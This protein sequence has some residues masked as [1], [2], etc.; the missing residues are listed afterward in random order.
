MVVR[1]RQQYRPRARCFR[2]GIS[3]LLRQ[4]RFHTR[5][6]RIHF[7]WRQFLSQTI[8][9]A[10]MGCCASRIA[11][12]RRTRP[13]QKQMSVRFSGSAAIGGTSFFGT[14]QT[15]TAT[16][17]YQTVIE[18]N[19]NTSAQIWNGVKRLWF[20][21]GHGRDDHEFAQHQRSRSTPTWWKF[22]RRRRGQRLNPLA[23]EGGFE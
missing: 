19:N 12:N 6:T 18:N 11:G 3:S 5:E 23:A 2:H 10:R 22:S 8:R 17:R 7:S 13:T 4:S 16:A 20:W 1:A 14:S 15:T 21:S 9:W